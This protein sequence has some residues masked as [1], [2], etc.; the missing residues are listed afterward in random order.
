MQEQSFF[1]MRCRRMGEI[2]PKQNTVHFVSTCSRSEKRKETQVFSLFFQ[3]SSPFSRRFPGLENC[4]ANFKIFSRIT[5]R[6]CT[7]PDFNITKLV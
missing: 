1:N 5:K 3:T 7:N 4:W 6:L 2:G